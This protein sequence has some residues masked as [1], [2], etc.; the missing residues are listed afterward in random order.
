MVD[1]CRLGHICEFL[2]TWNRFIITRNC[3][4]T[5]AMG[6]YNAVLEWNAGILATGRANSLGFDLLLVCT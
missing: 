4:Q 3:F 1:Y 2:I 6:V 5:A